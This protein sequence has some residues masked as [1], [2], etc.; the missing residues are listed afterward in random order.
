MFLSQVISVLR[1]PL[2]PNS[3]A[4]PDVITVKSLAANIVTRELFK[5]SNLCLR[6]FAGSKYDCSMTR[7]LWQRIAFEV[8]E[9][10]ALLGEILAK[11]CN[12]YVAHRMRRANQVW[13]LYSRLYTEKTL[14]SLVSRLLDRLKN[15]PQ[16]PLAFLLSATL[17]KWE[18]ERI[19]DNDMKR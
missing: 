18:Q 9:R 6:D 7:E 4:R 1:R 12:F 3:H 13:N 19:T 8:N 11:Q 2:R 10:L 5:E 17:F 15:R 16:K 14:R